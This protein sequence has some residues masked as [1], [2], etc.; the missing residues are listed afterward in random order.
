M[1]IKKVEIKDSEDATLYPKTSTDQ[2]FD[3]KGK[4]LSTT[5]IELE[6][7][8]KNGSGGGGGSAYGII[9]NEEG[10]I[11][12]N[13]SGDTLRVEGEGLTSIKLSSKGDEGI[14]QDTIKITSRFPKWEEV[15]GDPL[16]L[17]NPKEFIFENNTLGIN[18]AN[19]GGGGSGGGLPYINVKNF[20]VMERNPE[21]GVM[22]EVAYGAKGDNTSPD[23]DTRAFKRA[24]QL[25]KELGSANIYIPDGNYILNETIQ[26]Y[27]NTNVEAS[28]NA[29]IKKNHTSVMFA[30][31]IPTEAY[32]GYEGGMVLPTVNPSI[33]NNGNIFFSGGTYDNDGTQ[34]SIFSLI[35][36]R[37]FEFNNMNFLDIYESHAFDLAGIA[38]V[39]IFNCVFRG[40]QYYR[41]GEVDQ[42]GKVIPNDADVN[43][44]SECIQL[45]FSAHQAFPYQIAGHD[46]TVCQRIR[47][48]KCVFGASDR[49]PAWNR[50]FGCHNLYLPTYDWLHNPDG[51]PTGNRYNFIDSKT[52]DIYFINNVVEGNGTLK[53]DYDENDPESFIIQQV[54][55]L[56]MDNVIIM[57]NKFRD[58]KG[59]ISV[60]VDQTPKTMINAPGR[61]D[62]NTSG[63]ATYPKSGPMPA[64]VTYI[65]ER[66][67][68]QTI[69]FSSSENDYDMDKITTHTHNGITYTIMWCKTTKYVARYG[70]ENALIMNNEMTNITCGI[71]EY[72]QVS[73]TTTN[74]TELNKIIIGAIKDT[75]GKQLIDVG[76]EIY[77][78]NE[79]NP[80]FVTR[81]QGTP[82]TDINGN[83]I[84]I[85]PYTLTVYPAFSSLQVVGTPVKIKGSPSK[86]ASTPIYL[87]GRSTV[88]SKIDL[89]ADG[90]LG[91]I[92]KTGVQ[93]PRA[94]KAIVYGN[95]IDGLYQESVYAQ[96]D[97][98]VRNGDYMHYI[99]DIDASRKVLTL[100]STSDSH[101]EVGRSIWFKENDDSGEFLSRS[102]K[103]LSIEPGNVVT[104]DAP[105]EDKI[106]VNY[107]IYTRDPYFMGETGGP[108]FVN[109][110]SGSYVRDLLIQKNVVRNIPRAIYIS[111]CTRTDVIGNHFFQ[112][113]ETAA[114]TIDGGDYHN[115]ISNIFSD[116]NDQAIEMRNPNY[117][118]ISNN[119]FLDHN[120]RETYRSKYPL[121]TSFTYDPRDTPVI[122]A[123][124][125]G[126]DDG[127]YG[128]ITGN[129]FYHNNSNPVK[130]GILA[131][132]G[133]LFV[134]MS[135]NAFPSAFV[136]RQ[137]NRS[138]VG[139]DTGYKG[140]DADT[141]QGKTLDTLSDIY[142][143]H[144]Q[145]GTVNGVAALGP[146]GKVPTSQLPTS[147]GSSGFKTIAL[148]NEET[149]SATQL[150]NILTLEGVNGITFDAKDGN[151][152]EITFDADGSHF[153][154]VSG[155]EQKI[156]DHLNDLEAHVTPADTLKWNR[157][158]DDL[159]IHHTLTEK[160]SWNAHRD[161]GDIH[162]TLVEKNKW[163]THE[164]NGDIHHT[165]DEKNKWN[166]H[167]ADLV[168][169]VTQDDKDK[170]NEH[171]DDGTIH[172]TL[173]EKNKWNTHEADLVRHV[174]QTD[175]D[176][177][178]THA[179][180]GDIHHTLAEKNKWNTHEADS[181]IHVTT[182]DKSN[183]N[184]KSDKSYVDTNLFNK[185]TSSKQTITPP[186]EFTKNINLSNYE[187]K[188]GS[189]SGGSCNLSTGS[190]FTINVDKATTISFTNM[191]SSS[192]YVQSVVIYLNMIAVY[193]VTFPSGVKWHNENIP[194]LTA[195]RVHEIIFRT[196]DNGATWLATLGGK[197]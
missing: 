72:P 69:L 35:N 68:M 31:T 14:T 162:H 108:S 6:Y 192:G 105:L 158:V 24:F 149:I 170:W 102:Y 174:T 48:D 5:I 175:K 81:I 195:G 104:I 146:D 189:N 3:D 128:N 55:L 75:L 76:T 143:P 28:R 8:T 124:G 133:T 21:T 83:S 165:L 151:V 138:D 173:D 74:S 111:G 154:R 188:I 148:P 125:N 45:D 114:V 89:N 153:Q 99:K 183:W 196:T 66:G 159:D 30:N 150:A 106:K 84:E 147:S 131:D 44:Y 87:R 191:P 97:A 164:A 67:D 112:V 167:E 57:N 34:G 42:N 46:G 136:V 22:E 80:R 103:V 185:T 13:Q 144:S 56:G 127:L 79:H 32:A 113:N 179:D 63:T 118:N 51:S 129:M 157:H 64:K 12:A 39:I 107:N 119:L 25:A 161:N 194:S 26:M 181:T 137:D 152:L 17:F 134:K 141:L 168:R 47:I 139:L 65:D 176:K 178:N 95:T 117:Y 171:A 92:S 4:P 172:H 20:K 10:M 59:G 85:A 9:Q 91:S 73:A 100:S 116:L 1:T 142:I 110:I 27:R 90:T 43:A 115:I 177:W 37:N 169:H 54:R 145:R 187:E 101:M 182:S 77:C 121:V 156:D 49:F 19:I 70:W 16:T 86:N 160:N 82:S 130:T 197:F 23:M 29:T 120:R 163:N 52:K 93:Q 109:A 11:S 166:T 15:A 186:V 126:D 140:N 61:R 78:G 123:T 33:K 36:A 60:D 7:A 41:T 184:G 132:A 50:A 180:N 38:D 96:W 155:V 88:P 122:F 98:L 135:N 94:E 193:A 53:Y 18:T 71:F 2:V 40:F 190:V 58:V 62:F